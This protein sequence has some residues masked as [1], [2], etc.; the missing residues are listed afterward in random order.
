MQFPTAWRQLEFTTDKETPKLIVEVA[1]TLM[2][3]GIAVGKFIPIVETPLPPKPAD[4]DDNRESEM[5][6][7]RTAAQAHN[8][9]AQAFQKSVRTRMTMNAV[10]RFKNVDKFYHC[11]S[12]DYRGRC[13]P[14]ATLADAKWG[15]KRQHLH[16]HD[17]DY[18]IR[19]RRRRLNSRHA[20]DKGGG[21]NTGRNG[22]SN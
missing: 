5:W 15:C 2:E 14:L 18:R 7:R 4:I 10:K 22:V 17:W 11:W 19:Y 21:G 9:N 13:Y 16:R 3:R 1:E 20:Q 12:F 8:Q 6:Y